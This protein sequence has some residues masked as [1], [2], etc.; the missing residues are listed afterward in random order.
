MSTETISSSNTES[1]LAM[2]SPADVVSTS[3]DP[4][5]LVSSPS[6]SPPLVGSKVIASMRALGHISMREN[7]HAHHSRTVVGVS[8]FVDLYYEFTTFT[9]FTYL[10]FSYNPPPPLLLRFLT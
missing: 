9:N 1:S 3:D 4:S 6:V 7:G 5:M 8:L 2:P 10:S